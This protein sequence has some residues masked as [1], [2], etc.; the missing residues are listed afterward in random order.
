MISFRE[1]QKECLDATEVHSK[2]II[3]A[4]TGA[5]KTLVGIG[6]TI[7]EFEKE[8]PQTIVVV[9]PRILLANQ[10]SS[11]YLEHITNASGCLCPPII[12]DCEEW[13]EW[14]TAPYVNVEEIEND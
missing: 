10:L 9:A 13:S 6:D 11:E 8:T 1:H 7:R 3:C 5:G 14:M 4:T 12:Y 2:G